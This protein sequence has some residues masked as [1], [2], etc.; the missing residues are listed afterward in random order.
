MATK[1]AEQEPK[2]ARS[3]TMRYLDN[4]GHGVYYSKDTPPEGVAGGETVDVT[5]AK[6]DQLLRD[7]PED[8]VVVKG[9]LGVAVGTPEAAV[10]TL[11]QLPGI[12]STLAKRLVEAGI[13]SHTALLDESNANVVEGIVPAHI[14]DRLRP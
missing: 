6:R 5:E 7:F 4:S 8:W 14:L 3:V 11:S 13:D 12:G 1:K 2:E 9:G 10:A